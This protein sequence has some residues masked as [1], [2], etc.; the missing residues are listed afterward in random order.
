PGEG[1]NVRVQV[2]GG[3]DVA[4]TKDAQFHCYEVNIFTA[5]ASD[6]YRAHPLQRC[7]EDS[8]MRFRMKVPMGKKGAHMVSL[9]RAASTARH[10]CFSKT[11][12][13]IV[14]A[15]ARGTKFGEPHSQ[16]RVI[17]KLSTWRLR[18]CRRCQVGADI[19]LTQ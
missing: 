19:D 6:F 7:K 17:V 9:C 5:H 18:F 10:A 14:I 13:G 11:E 12:R 8:P 3:I 15:V 1:C 2:Y 4:F 16:D